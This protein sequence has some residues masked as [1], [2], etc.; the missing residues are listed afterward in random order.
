MWFIFLGIGFAILIAGGLYLRSRM[1][2][3][4]VVLGASPRW[5]RALRYLV[6]WLLFS[7]PLIAVSTVVFA[8]VSGKSGMGRYDGPVVTWLLVYPFFVT[9]L[10]LVQSLPWLL[11]FELGQALMRLARR[12]GLA[13]APWPRASRVVAGA[14]L[15]VLGGFAL[16]TP[17]RIV[18]ERGEVRTR[19][20][21]VAIGAGADQAAPSAGA[22]QVPPFRIAFLADLQQD[23]Y[24]GPAELAPIL[25]RINAMRADVVLS[26][27]DWINSGPDHI[28]A[29]A[30]TASALRGRL[31]TYS[32]R[33]D[34][35]HFAYF[36]RERSV[37]EIERALAARGVPV[38]ANEVRWF[39]HH[40]RKIGVLFL[41]YNYIVRTEEPKIRAL[42]A[43]LAQ[44]DAAIVVSHQ[45]DERVAALVAGKVDLVLA[46]HTHGGQVNPFLGW[47]HHSLA[48][49]E[50]RY[51]DGRYSLGS[52]EVIVTAGV[53]YS[54]VPFRYASP[55][56]IELIELTW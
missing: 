21:Q 11:S 26:G 6:T 34:H 52:T 28:E 25:E 22:A 3:A 29:A 55:G 53:G 20:Y 17:A 14:T 38:L 43:E 49:V 50:T 32:V 54:V 39:S 51:V 23:V 10:V 44:A 42:V 15:L 1:S 18:L 19:V 40:G 9:L 36:D 7:Y 30:E 41:N 48:R 33:G 56:S 13:P 35:E 46:A 24:T 27:G 31:G 16:Y 2:R 37:A 5:V 8:L 4:L 12:L 47:A 45:F